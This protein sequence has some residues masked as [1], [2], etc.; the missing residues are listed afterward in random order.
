MLHTSMGLR[1]EL[2]LKPYENDRVPLNYLDDSYEQNEDFYVAALQAYSEYRR[3]AIVLKKLSDDPEQYARVFPS[4]RPRTDTYPGDE[5]GD[6][7]TIYARQK[8]S[9]PRGFVAKDMCSFILSFGA[10]IS[11][12]EQTVREVVPLSRWNPQAGE[13]TMPMEDVSF[14]GWVSFGPSVNPLPRCTC[15]SFRLMLGFDRNSRR[16]LYRIADLNTTAPSTFEEFMELETLLQAQQTSK[17]NGHFLSFPKCP[18]HQVSGVWVGVKPGI[19]NDKICFFV[20]LGLTKTYVP[21]V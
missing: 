4:S 5:F 12:S 13:I 8:L 17:A 18:L 11:K 2:E 1:L 9:I 19:S 7:H 6:K 3:I 10:H 20:E 15:I 16:L 14:A 21:R